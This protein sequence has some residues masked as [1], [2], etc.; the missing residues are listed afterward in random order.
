MT[1][2]DMCNQPTTEPT[3]RMVVDGETI[4]VGECC[5]WALYGSE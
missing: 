4:V 3:E 5:F 2:C 1:K